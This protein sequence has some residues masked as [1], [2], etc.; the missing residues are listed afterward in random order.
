V[1]VGFFD[2]CWIGNEAFDR[3]AEIRP[4]FFL[5]KI[6]DFLSP[7][8]DCRFDSRDQPEVLVPG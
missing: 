4:R 5:Q 7:G 3:P 6:I 8:E 1:G 2:L